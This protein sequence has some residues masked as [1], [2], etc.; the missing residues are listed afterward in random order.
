[1]QHHAYGGVLLGIAALG[2]LA[3]GF[4]QIIEATAR[5]AAAVKSDARNDLPR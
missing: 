4:F 1:M 2:L 5:R 3:F